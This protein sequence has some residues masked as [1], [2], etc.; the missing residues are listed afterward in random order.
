M[1]K[2][3]LL[4]EEYLVINGDIV[5]Q[6]S[7][8]AGGHADIAV[9]ASREIPIVRGTVYEREGGKRPECLDPPSGKKT[10]NYRDRIYRWNDDKE[11]AVRSMKFVIDRL[12]ASGFADEARVMNTQLERIIPTF[13][14]EEEAQ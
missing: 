7:R 3:T 4:P 5:V 2:L 6:L 12:E 1:L 8:V 13:W 14:E 10:K 11:R 9:E